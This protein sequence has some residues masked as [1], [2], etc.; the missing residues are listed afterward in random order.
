MELL[1][2]QQLCTL[3]SGKT[4]TSTP[5][6]ILTPIRLPTCLLQPIPGFRDSG[7]ILP[8][9]KAYRPQR[10]HCAGAI[11]DICLHQLSCTLPYITRWHRQ[12]IAG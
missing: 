12:Y 11:L 6:N 3:A 10:Q 8:L 9:L 1:E 2:Q 5:G 4:A 7:L